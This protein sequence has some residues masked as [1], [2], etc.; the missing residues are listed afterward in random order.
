[1]F[2]FTLFV[3]YTYVVTFVHTLL[4]LIYVVVGGYVVVVVTRLPFT[5]V[6]YLYVV[7]WLVCY[8]V[9]GCY[10]RY[11]TRY[12]WFT[13]THICRSCHVT[14]RSTTHTLHTHHTRLHTLFVGLRYVVYTRSGYGYTFTLRLPLVYGYCVYVTP[15]ADVCYRLLT[16]RLIY[17]FYVG[18]YIVAD[19]TR[20]V[21]FTVLIYTVVTLLRYRTRLFVVTV[22]LFA[23]T[24]TLR[25]VTFTLVGLRS[26]LRLTVYTF[27]FVAV[28]TFTL[29]YIYWFTHVAVT[30]THGYRSRLRYG[31]I[32]RLRLR[33]FYGCSLHVYYVYAHV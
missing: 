8:H 31:R 23:Y 25:F 17:T 9:V 1:L 33:T 11:R 28:A 13:H 10:V 12:V 19:Y 16:L 14:L 24:F 2:T 32:L 5:H 30:V 6:C 29:V 27:T 7:V 15:F 3:V 4:L 21:P 18:C 22:T 20:L 26:R